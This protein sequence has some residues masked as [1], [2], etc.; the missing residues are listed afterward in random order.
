MDDATNFILRKPMGV[1]A[2]I[3]PWNLPLYLSRNAPALPWEILSSKPSEGTPLLH[4]FVKPLE[5]I[6]FP[7]GV[8]NIVCGWA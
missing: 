3:I 6:Q 2:L 4:A 8:V 5:D 1:V 7:K